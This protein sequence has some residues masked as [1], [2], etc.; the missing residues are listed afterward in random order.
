MKKYLE[1]RVVQFGVRS[2][3]R[4]RELSHILTIP[5]NAIRDLVKVR[6]TLCPCSNFR[7]HTG[8]HFVVIMQG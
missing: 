7:V 2:E 4:V 5:E 8:T 6:R 1:C 3:V